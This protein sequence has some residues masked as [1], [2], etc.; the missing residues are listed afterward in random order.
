MTFY[1]DHL[2]VNFDSTSLGCQ[3]CNSSCANIP[4]VNDAGTF[5]VANASQPLLNGGPNIRKPYLPPSNNVPRSIR[6]LP[7]DVPPVP[8]MS[9][10]SRNNSISQLAT[11]DLN[12]TYSND[13]AVRMSSKS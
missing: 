5:H 13:I 1:Q 9:Y 2:Y 12:R 6:E 4:Q 3:P 10:N 8:G 7:P 11:N